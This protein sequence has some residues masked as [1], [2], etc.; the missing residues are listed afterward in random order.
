MN[1]DTIPFAATH[2]GELIKDELKERGMSQKQLSDITGIGRSVLNKTING[3]RSLTRELAVALE[4]TFGIPADYWLNLQKQ[5]D[6]DVAQIAKRNNFQ[7]TIPITIPI[8]D[9]NLLREVVR[10]FGWACML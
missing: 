5:F 10:K 4:N 6:E 3:K 1:K 2:P 7:E 8:S 9:R